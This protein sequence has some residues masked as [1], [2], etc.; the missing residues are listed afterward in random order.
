M[1]K[2]LLIIPLSDVGIKDIALVGGKNASLGEMIQNLT[3][4]G[5]NVPGGFV[6]TA[7][8]YR[9]FLKETGLQK[10]IKETLTGLNVSNLRDLARRGKSIREIIKSNELPKDLKKEIVAAYQKME[11][12]Y[13]KNV[14]V[15]VRS[16]ATAE[17]LPGASF[18]GEHETFLGVRGSDDLLI[19]TKAA[20]ASLFTDRAISYRVDKGFDHFKIA[21][22][23]GVQ[24]MI[25]S[26]LASS[27]VMFTLDTESGFKDLVLING[28]WGLG[29]MIVQGQVTPDE[30]LIFKKNSRPIISKKIGEKAKK[31]IYAKGQAGGTKIIRTSD[32]EKANFILTEPEISKLADWGIAIEEHY[33][34][35]HGKWTP[36][37]IEWAKD[38]KTKELFIVRPRLFE[39]QGIHTR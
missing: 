6:I 31:M 36:M 2:K 20:M 39:N 34:R 9:Y 30:F 5:I 27:G 35:K 37:D 19:Y 1:P 23:V 15:A 24:K 21:L 13:G 16:S 12:K 4:K 8:A 32:R 33:T 7:H 3:P 18:A 28:S 22:S 10:Y 38:G 26:D 14:D 29:E 17:D 11:K 25:R